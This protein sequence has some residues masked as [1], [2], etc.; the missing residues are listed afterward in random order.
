ME[1]SKVVEVISS[2]FNT[3]TN[4][5]GCCSRRRLTDWILITGQLP[6]IFHAVQ[7]NRCWGPVTYPTRQQ[8]NNPLAE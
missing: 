3:S 2:L 7:L 6:S 1:N 8:Y 5:I 4:V